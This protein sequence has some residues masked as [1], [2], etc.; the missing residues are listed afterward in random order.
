M[1]VCVY[2]CVCVCVCVYVQNAAF[3]HSTLTV[4]T[5]D[6]GGHGVLCS[7]HISCNTEGTGSHLAW[8]GDK[9]FNALNTATVLRCYVNTIFYLM[10][11]WDAVYSC[12][13]WVHEEQYE[14]KQQQVLGLSKHMHTNQTC[15]L[16]PLCVCA[17]A[18]L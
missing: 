1:C 10:H 7:P 17:P 11:F 15:I 5:G 4:H 8:P 14:M 18:A 9:A 12:M 2:V 13:Q 3:I 6:S 16:H